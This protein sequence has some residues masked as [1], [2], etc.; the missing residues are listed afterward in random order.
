MH[1]RQKFTHSHVSKELA[2]KLGI[3]KRSVQ[4]HK[5]DT[6]KVMVGS[7]KGKSGTVNTVYLGKGTVLIDGILRK[8]SKAKEIL[9][10]IKASNVYITD[11]NL[12]DKLRKEKLGVKA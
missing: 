2:K 8:N 5:G 6:V 1:V 10:P 3:K 11:M 4:V 7:N 9:I 12:T